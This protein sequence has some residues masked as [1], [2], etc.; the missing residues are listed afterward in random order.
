M[1]EGQTAAKEGLPAAAEVVV[2]GGGIIGCSTAYFLAKRGIPVVLCEKGRIAGEQSSRNWGFVRQQGR[3]PAEV[4]TIMESLRIWRGLETELQADI[5][6]HQGGVLYLGDSDEELAGFEGWLEIARQHQIDSRLLSSA[7]VARRLPGAE[8]RWKAGLLTPSDGRAEPAKAAPA[9]AAAAERLGAQVLPD[10]AVRALET[11]AG[12]VTGV[13]TEHGPIACRAVVCAA[14]AWSS[15][16]S[17]NLGVTLPQLRVRG[18]VCRTA[19]LPDVWNGGIW[20]RDFGM[21]RRQDGGYNLA[22]GG[23][24]EVEVVPDSFRFFRAFFPS[25]RMAHGELKLRFGRSF[26][27]ALMTPGRWRPD[28]VTPFEKTRVLDPEP[29]RPILDRVLASVRAAFPELRDLKVE[30][31]WAGMIDVTPDAIP[32]ISAVEQPRGYF[33]A[34]GFSGH[35]FGIGPGAG[36]LAAELVMGEPTTVDVAPFR[37]G[38]FSDGT[39]LKP[40]QAF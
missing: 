30:E 40:G 8:R 32:V 4:P 12:A 31:R 3:D 20:C 15:L 17:R 14:G 11:A 33:L 16:F 13:V 34:T 6:W 2:I 24:V 25:A 19:P 39:K 36:K 26:F 23:V 18:S 10:C 29:S 35:G 28:Q 1:S 27:D 22:H 5:G 9:I 37:F 38:R 21:K 7:E